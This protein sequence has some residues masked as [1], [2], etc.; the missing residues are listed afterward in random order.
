[1]QY[2]RALCFK[3]RFISLLSERLFFCI[4]NLE[5][6]M[7]GSFLQKEKTNKIFG[8]LLNVTIFQ[9]IKW[10]VDHYYWWI[11]FYILV[12][13]FDITW[14]KVFL[15]H[16][17]NLLIIENNKNDNCCRHWYIKFIFFFFLSTSLKLKTKWPGIFTIFNITQTN[18]LIKV[19]IF[20]SLVTIAG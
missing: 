11:I 18:C 8:G 16:F 15:E 14:Y 2:K 6:R 1:M 3:I 4:F 17:I 20:L 10:Q 12:I 9:N 13:K 5:D 19:L 7:F